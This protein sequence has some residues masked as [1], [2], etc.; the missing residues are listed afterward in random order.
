MMDLMLVLE[1]G[2]GKGI[3]SIKNIFKL[4]YMFVLPNIAAISTATILGGATFY[5]PR[6][7]L[8]FVLGLQL[9]ITII[10]QYMIQK[11]ILRHLRNEV[12]L[13]F[14]P[15][16]I[17]SFIKQRLLFFIIK[18]YVPFLLF[19]FV[20]LGYY[21]KNNHHMFILV[22]FIS[23]IMIIYFQIYLA[24][25]I[26]YCTN[27]IKPKLLHILQVSFLFICIAFFLF[28]VMVSGVFILETLEGYVNKVVFEL[29]YINPLFISIPMVTLSVISIV[30]IYWIK[31]INTNVLIYNRKASFRP[32]TIWLEQFYEKIYG[33]GLSKLQRLLFAKDIKYILRNNKVL[34]IV[35]GIYHTVNLTFLI[36]FFLLSLKEV[37][38][39]GLFIPKL[40]LGWMLGL[41]VFVAILSAGYKEILEIGNDRKVLKS[42]HIRL[43]E[44]KV[45]QE[46]TKVLRAFVFPKITAVFFLFIVTLLIMQLYT[47]AMIFVLNYVLTFICRKTLEL[48]R[49]KKTN[50]QPKNNYVFDIVNFLLMM[51]SIYILLQL[52]NS[53]ADNIFLFQ[54][55]L[56]I[57]ISLLYCFHLFT[58]K[59]IINHKGDDDLA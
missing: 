23:I 29:F 40:Y 7:M 59:H 19:N 44:I 34:I 47:L 36:V 50:Y 5:H 6:E 30:L 8:I 24:M 31:K 21:I 55:L 18:F 20:F 53:Q 51:V 17:L 12:I 58:L 13:N 52:F 37:T 26:R 41:L 4:F 11:N 27:T 39:L 22:A 43:P 1:L 15:K 48:W 10:I 3:K 56:L 57:A 46:K 45:I 32:S 14:V 2:N 35:F 42:Y 33:F 16:K 54:T 9:F 38:E 28:Y 25:I 49:V